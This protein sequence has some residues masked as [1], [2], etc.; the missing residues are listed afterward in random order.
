MHVVAVEDI[1][2]EL[3]DD[4]DR[5]LVGLT[6]CEVA[7]R[8]PVESRLAP[9][10]VVHLH[11][12]RAA[13]G[14]V[15]VAVDLHDAVRRLPQVERE[16][17]EHAV[18]AEPHVL[19]PPDVEPRDERVG[20]LRPRDRVQPV[21]GKNQ[22][23]GRGELVGAGRL[24]AKVRNH[25][26]LR[27]TLLQDLQQAAAAHCREAVAAAG[28]HLAAEVDVD[29]VPAGELGLHPPVNRGVG[30]LDAAES[31]VGEDDA[32]PE[33]VVSGV[34]LPDRDLMV[35]IE[36]LGQGGE[37]QAAGATPDDGDPHSPNLRCPLL[38]R[39][40]MLPARRPSIEREI[41]PCLESPASPA[42]W[43]WSPGGRAAS[44]G[45]YARPS[46]PR[47]PPWPSWTPTWHR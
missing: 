8:E 3:S 6:G 47:V 14:V 1:V 30:V 40:D 34:A 24:G 38:V 9:D 20:V 15:G 4:C 2:E 29:V 17:V 25:P 37:V 13:G 12:E 7:A 23:V 19:A 21:A 32:E 11:D 27:A 18:G 31:L 39:D 26:E 33:R 36:L 10:L 28:D 5:R 44:A 42:G 41:C 35:G 46:R 16:R 45:P 22:V 43:P